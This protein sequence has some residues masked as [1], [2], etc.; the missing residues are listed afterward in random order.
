MMKDTQEPYIKASHI[1]M[2][3]DGFIELLKAHWYPKRVGSSYKKTGPFSWEEPYGENSVRALYLGRISRLSKD[4]RMC[5]IY[6]HI[7]W[8]PSFRIVL[9]WR[10]KHV[11]TLLITR[12][13]D[14]PL[15]VQL[16]CRDPR[17]KDTMFQHFS[18][19][20][21]KLEAQYAKPGQA[22]A[23]NSSPLPVHPSAARN[24]EE[25][26][27]A[28]SR[29]PSVNLASEAPIAPAVGGPPPRPAEPSTEDP[30]TDWF[31]WYHACKNAGYKVTLQDVADRRGYSLSNVKKRHTLYRAERGLE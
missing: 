18:A 29:T 14:E 17:V 7:C 12:L 8:H 1:S 9:P 4:S 19:E 25:G 31:D 15:Y 30:L 23:Q 10:S 11:M 20:L 5:K 28:S 24:S 27:E 22:A 2:S 26:S 6:E 13:E 21:D 3:M 16:V